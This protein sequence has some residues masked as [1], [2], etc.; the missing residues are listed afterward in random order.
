MLTNQFTIKYDYLI[1]FF[2]DVPLFFEQELRDV[3]IFYCV[4][5]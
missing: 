2:L 5:P 4:L 1:Q 3:I